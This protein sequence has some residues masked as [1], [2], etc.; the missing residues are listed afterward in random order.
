MKQ[1]VAVSLDGAYSPST[2]L[3]SRSTTTIDSGVRSS[4]ATPLGLI[5]TS[6]SPGTRAERLP[7]V[8]AT[9]RL[10]TS[11]WWSALTVRRTSS[12]VVIAAPIV[13]GSPR[14]VWTVSSPSAPLLA[15]TFGN[16]KRLAR[17]AAVSVTGDEGVEEPEGRGL[18]GLLELARHGQ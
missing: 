5:T 14:V 6:S 3:A 16:V 13:R 9:S 17:P 12:S 15:V 1:C 8:H 11:S 4:K 7:L 2:T 10:R 18:R